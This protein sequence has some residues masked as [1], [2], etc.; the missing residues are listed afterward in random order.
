MSAT[1]REGTTTWLYDHFAEKFFGHR[2]DQDLL[3]LKDELAKSPAPAGARLVSRTSEVR[4][5]VDDFEKYMAVVWMIMLYPDVHDCSLE[6]RREIT[7]FV[8]ETFWRDK[9]PLVQV[10]DYLAIYKGVPAGGLL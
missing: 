3:A 7:S 8:I 9:K 6:Q 10:Q 5:F 2:N 1:P 4:V